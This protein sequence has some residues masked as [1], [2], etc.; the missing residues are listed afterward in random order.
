MTIQDLT[1][2]GAADGNDEGFCGG[3]SVFSEN[4]G[5]AIFNATG[6]LTLQDVAFTDNPGGFLGGAISNNGNLSM[7]EVSFTNDQGSIGGALFS[8]GTVTASGVTFANDATGSTD[9]AAVYLSAAPPASPT[10]RWSVVGGHRAAAVAFT[11]VA[12]PSR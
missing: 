2:T 6:N 3:C 9:E 5:G 8:R 1:F 11:T 12:R 4:G 7:Q 10:R